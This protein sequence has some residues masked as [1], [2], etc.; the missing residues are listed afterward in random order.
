MP[1]VGIIDR[2]GTKIGAGWIFEDIKFLARN[3][4]FTYTVVQPKESLVGN[5]THGA[6]S[7]LHRKVLILFITNGKYF[8]SISYSPLKLLDRKKPD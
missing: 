2:N 5:N 1:L 7:L 4:N 6:L 8:I 3:L